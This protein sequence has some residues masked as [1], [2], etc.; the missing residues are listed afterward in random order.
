MITLTCAHCGGVHLA[1]NGHA[2]NGK[3]RLRCHD[4]G[5]NSVLRQRLAHSV[6][7]S[8]SFSETG[9][10]HERGL[11]LFL[12]EHNATVQSRPLQKNY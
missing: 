6:R 8:L 5:R 9:E 4:C 3:R 1:P 10:W 11:L 2:P 7:R 12:H